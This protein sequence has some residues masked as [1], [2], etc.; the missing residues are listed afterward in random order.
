MRNQFAKTLY[1][2]GCEHR[3]VCIVVSDISPAGSMEKF[4][5][6]F[7]ERF[8]NVG[9]SE[10]AMIGL[11][12]GLALRGLKTYAYT[13]AAFTIYRPFE[14]IRDD[15]CYQNLPVTLV[16]MGSGIVYSTLGGTHHTAEDV[17]IMSALPNMSIIA[18]CD[19]LEVVEATRL[20][21]VFDGPLY[22]KLG[23]AGE[24]VLTEDAVEPFE[25]GK[26]RYL[27][28]GSDVCLLSYGIITEMAARLA[29]RLEAA[30]RS[31][32]LVSVHTLKPLDK[33]GILKA[34]DSHE[35]VYVIE[36]HSPYG[37]LGPQVKEIAWDNSVSCKL[38]TFSLKDEFIHF[39]GSHKGLREAHGLE[40]ERLF[41]EMKA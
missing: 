13:I 3:N 23:K 6:E 10:Q 29:K 12:A 37:G 8:V 34:L 36:E 33:A 32:S 20:S 30:G 5:E 14:F 25:F 41:G 17:A 7:P 11:C 31:V 21:A 16:G 38:R 40:E 4:R 27:K 1:E 28:R 26:L 2:V 24:P 19:P 35:S 15:I 22:L 18:P 9:V 39:Y